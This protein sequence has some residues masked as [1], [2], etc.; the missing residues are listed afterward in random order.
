M[1]IAVVDR[2]YERVTFYTRGID[3][4]T[5]VSVRELKAANKTKDSTD[6]ADILKQITSGQAPSF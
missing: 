1:V 4:S 6:I 2:D 3:A 5:D